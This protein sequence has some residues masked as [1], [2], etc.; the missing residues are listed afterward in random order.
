MTEVNRSSSAAYLR[1]CI[2]SF[3]AA[4]ISHGQRSFFIRSLSATGS[5]TIA[6]FRAIGFYCATALTI[7]STQHGIDHGRSAAD[8]GLNGNSIERTFP[9]AGTAFHAGI[10]I[11]DDDVAFVHHKHFAGTYFQAHPAARAFLFVEFQRND[12]SEI[13][14]FSHIA[15]LRDQA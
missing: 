5:I 9:A 10:A 15:L 8:A 12:I 13:N 14:Q 6:E 2:F 4:T 1:Y 3:L 11:L 7:R